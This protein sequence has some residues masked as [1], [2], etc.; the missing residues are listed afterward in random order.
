MQKEKAAQIYRKLCAD[1]RL[2]VETECTAR[3]L[4]QIPVG[5]IYILVWTGHLSA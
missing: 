2:G 3:C 4:G 5:R 1:T